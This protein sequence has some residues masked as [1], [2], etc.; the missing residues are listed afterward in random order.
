MP[1]PS[2]LELDPAHSAHRVLDSAQAAQFCGYASVQHWRRLHQMGKVPKAVR[3]NGGKLG[4]RLA[5]LIT[6]NQ[7]RGGEA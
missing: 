6:F 5:D 4:W 1:T 3:I 7:C 2:I